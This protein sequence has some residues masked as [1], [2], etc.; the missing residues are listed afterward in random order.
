[1]TYRLVRLA[2]GSYD[3]ELDG[4]IV[5]SVVRDGHHDHAV[6]WLAEILDEA[7]PRPAPFVESVHEFGSFDEVAAWLGHPDTVTMTRAVLF[8]HR[9][10]A[11]S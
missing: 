7:G 6:R 8:S 5:A 10:A 3:L 1:M 11:P 9:T 2:P 4:D